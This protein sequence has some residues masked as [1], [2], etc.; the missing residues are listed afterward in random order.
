MVKDLKSG[1]CFR[2]DHLIEAH[3]EKMLADKK[4]EAGLRKEITDLMPKVI[5]TFM[6]K[7]PLLMDYISY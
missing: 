5:I 4:L 2:A 7:R 3:L 1:Q 6:S